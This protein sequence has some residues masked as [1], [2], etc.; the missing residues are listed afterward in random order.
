[1]SFC[2]VYKIRDEGFSYAR[3]SLKSRGENGSYYFAAA[4]KNAKKTWEAVCGE[5]IKLKVIYLTFCLTEITVLNDK[6]ESTFWK[7]MI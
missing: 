1:M 7:N 5:L 2:S 6:L 3:Q 4:T